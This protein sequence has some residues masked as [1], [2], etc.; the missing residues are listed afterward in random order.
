MAVVESTERLKTGIE[1]LDELIEGGLIKGDIH[2]LA[3]GPGTGKTIFASNLVY[4]AAKDFALKSVYATFEESAE[5]FRQN[6]KSIGINFA[7]LESSNLVSIVD[8]DAVRGKE[9]ESNISLLLAAVKDA[10]ANILVV[11]SL[12]ALLLA[13]E[14]PF[15]LR[16][17]VKS[18]YRSL[19]QM[20]V[21][22]LMTVSLGQ[23]E[24]IGAEAF[25]CD[26]VMLL[27]NW[28]DEDRFKT[29]FMVLKMRGT[30]HSRKYHSVILTPKLKIS[31]Y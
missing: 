9:L 26:S 7:P 10:R 20:K 11:D 13:C 1:G 24:R 12:T 8:L 4:N 30:E 23:N 25:I 3:G 19:K 31:N 5:S 28:L 27:E 6:M 14:T 29:R 16:T 22:T 15:E 17:F 21:T 18:L 2:L